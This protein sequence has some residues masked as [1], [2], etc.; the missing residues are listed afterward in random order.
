M[1]A[2]NPNP[3]SQFQAVSNPG[4][5]KSVIPQSGPVSAGKILQASELT[6]TERMMLEKTF[7]YDGVS[8]VPSDLANRMPISEDA[9]RQQREALL[10]EAAGAMPP[11]MEL[12]KQ[13]L[14]LSA[15][16]TQTLDKVPEALMTKYN[17]M[18]AEAATTTA[19]AA[20]TAPA[21]SPAASP[22]VNPNIAAAFEQ[23]RK[24]GVHEAETQDIVKGMHP[25]IAKAYSMLSEGQADV[26]LDMS[27]PEAEAGPKLS[28]RKAELERRKKD[29]L[30]AIGEV[31]EEVL[32]DFKRS[33]LL[34]KLFTHTYLC[35]DGDLQ[36]TF[37]DYHSDDYD[38]MS[39]QLTIDKYKNR[40][41]KIDLESVVENS[42][43]LALA[44]QL[45]EVKMLVDG[46]WITRLSLPEGMSVADYVKDF[47]RTKLAPTG[48][49]D[50][51][52]ALRAWSIFVYNVLVNGSLRPVVL[53]ALRRFQATV[54]N[55]QFIC[56]DPESF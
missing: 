10:A 2:D 52:T 36:L 23:A 24:E 14:D 21:A 38:A 17:N 50:D 13:D 51:D 45:R 12:P 56:Q 39:Q 7:G 9:L 30:A 16:P 33:V 34:G 1:T 8:P 26:K 47:D 5:G 15:I 48:L 19:K 11:P 35:F 42:R 55:L 28:V 4:K 32:V 53:A 43:R 54:L 20:A 3:T 49:D 37:G 29:R 6:A 25:D 31:D 40:V 41:S 44:A 22:A 46:K 18:I 27:D